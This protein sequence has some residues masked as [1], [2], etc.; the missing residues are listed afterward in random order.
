VLVVGCNRGREARLF[1][2]AGAREVWGIDVMKDV[3]LDYPDKRAHYAQMSAESMQLDDE[4][5]DVV[6]CLAT[7]EHIARPEDAYREIGRVTAPEGLAYVHS[8]PLWNAREG[9]HKGDIF[10]V[11]RYP[12]IHLRFDPHELKQLCASGEIEYPHTVDD[13][14]AQID[15]MTSS[16]HFNKRP[17]RDYVRIC[18]ELEGFDLERNK[19]HLEP[20]SV[21]ALISEDE[22]ARLAERGIDAIELRALTHTLVAWR[23]RRPWRLPSPRAW[24]GARQAR[25]RRLARRLRAPFYDGGR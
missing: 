2:D 5:F 18:S 25:V 10:D 14:D 15:Y 22:R 9:H 8:A 6:F 11:D 4:L 13:I 20:E 21:L 19:L 17:A 12:W 24:I 1:L 7:M 16:D 3:G 23:G